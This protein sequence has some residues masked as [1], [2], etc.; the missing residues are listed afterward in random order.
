MY[1]YCISY[2]SALI[3]CISAF[4]LL[5]WMGAI[6]QELSHAVLSA[7]NNLRRIFHLQHKTH[8]DRCPKLAQHTQLQ[9]V[10]NTCHHLWQV[11]R[12]LLLPM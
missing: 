12:H 2:I 1:M 11:K 8:S 6:A 5:L 7:V 9:P 10:A 4:V 3:I